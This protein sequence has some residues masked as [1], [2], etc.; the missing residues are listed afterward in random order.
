VV[1]AINETG[2]FIV[3]EVKRIRMNWVLEGGKFLLVD[4]KRNTIFLKELLK[5]IESN[6]GLSKTEIFFPS[7]TESFSN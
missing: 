7:L 3:K 5:L 2:K 6:D 4:S 1:P